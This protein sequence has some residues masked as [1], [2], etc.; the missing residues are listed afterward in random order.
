M[1]K[2]FVP[3]LL[4][5][6]VAAACGDG[7]SSSTEVLSPGELPPGEMTFGLHHVMTKQGV[8]SAIL[9][10]DTAFQQEDGRRFDL[11]GVHLQFFTATGAESGTLTS[12]TGEYN[13]NEGS[14]VARDSVVLITKSEEGT[15]R[16]ETEEL[17]YDT[18]TEQIWSDSAFVLDRGG[19]IS[20]GSS[21]R[22]DVYGNNWTATGLETDEVS[23][24]ATEITF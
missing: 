19:M 18:R 7:T 21:F 11:R 8:R 5:A 23:T 22:S 9:D 16:L 14:F 20:R 4:L 3:V 17:F 13:P 12:R 15:R 24:G 2:R 1:R 6:L 10:A